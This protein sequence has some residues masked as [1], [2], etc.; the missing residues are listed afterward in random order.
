MLIAVDLDDTLVDFIDPFI[1]Y[2]EKRF[3][4]RHSKREFNTYNFWE[5]IGGTRE[6]AI[7]L[8]HDFRRTG[9]LLNLPPMP[10][11]LPAVNQLRQYSELVIITSRP[12]L[13]S[14]DTEEL[15]H[16]RFSG[17]FSKIY[18]T[19]YWGQMGEVM[20]K[21]DL[22]RSLGVTVLIEDN[23]GYALGC[24][25]HVG[26]VFLFNQPWNQGNSYPSNVKRVHFWG[27]VVDLLEP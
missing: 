18:I 2:Y 24:A 16:R 13:F 11:A 22:C 26:Q 12:V 20:T 14:Q 21:E 5:V 10:G 27:D 23:P 9:A 7:E 15:V 25:E 1:Q 4:M 19:N 6:E 3:G 8:V 17:A